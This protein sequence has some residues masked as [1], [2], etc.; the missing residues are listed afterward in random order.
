MNITRWPDLLRLDPLDD[1]WRSLMR[2]GSLVPDGA[3][4]QMR[5]DVREQ[6]GRY[7][8]KAELPGVKKEDID[9]R[10]DGRQ[11]SLS[12]E[13]RREREEKPSG[14]EASRSWRSERYYGHVSRSFTLADEIDESQAQA[15]YQDGVLE[16]VLP[17]KA[18][19]STRRLVVE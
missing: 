7:T 16:L 18:A 13:V 3:T 11:V 4:P 5:L 1:P 8:V 14:T 6:D 10:I 17:K 2:P 12:A 15:H 19:S 9:V